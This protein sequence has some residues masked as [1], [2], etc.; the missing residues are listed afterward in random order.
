[1]KAEAQPLSA[2]LFANV[3]FLVPF[4]QRSYSWDRTNWERLVDDIQGLLDE[5]LEK[6]HF[7]GPLVCSLQSATPGSV[8]QFQLIDGQQ[9]I[10]T[11]SVL[12]IAIRDEAKRSDQ[13]E[14][15]EEIDENYLINKRRKALERYK[16]VPRTGDRE[17]FTALVDSKSV[18]DP[19]SRLAS[20]HEFFTKFIRTH[21]H[22][23][24]EYL[25]K[26]FITVVNRLFLVSIT[27]DK[28]DPYEIFESL[29]STGLPLQESDLIRNFL[30][31]QIPLEDQEDFQNEHWAPFEAQFDPAAGESTLSA[32]G[33][34]RDFLMRGGK[35]SKSKETFND[36]KRHYEEQ[37]LSPTEM[38]ALLQRFVGH[39]KSIVN[40]DSVASPKVAKVLRQFVWMEAST[41][42]PV[43]LNL[44]ER[45]HQKT[46][47]DD[48]FVACVSDLNSFILRRSI[49]GESTRGY[50]KLFCTLAGQLDGD[51]QSQI[52]GYLLERGWPDD[53]A[54][55]RSLAEF[56]LYRREFKKCRIILE[57]LERSDGHKEVVDL[58][59]IQI[60]HV[61]PQKLPGGKAGQEWKGMLG[62][63]PKRAHERLVHTLGNLTL[64]GYNPTLSNRAFSEKRKELAQSKLTLNKIFEI[65]GEKEGKLDP[66][67]TWNVDQITSRGKSLAAEVSGLWVRPDSN[68]E[69]VPPAKS[70]SAGNKG[71]QRRKEYWAA[72][73]DM[74][75]SSGVSVRPVR[76]IEGR[77]CDF[78]LPM[79]DV[80]LSA[81]LVT[82]KNQLTVAFQFARA[83]GKQIYDG[84]VADRE[85]IDAG[86]ETPPTWDD[87]KKPTITFVRHNVSIRDRYDWLDQHNWIIAT[88][89]Q[90]EN[91]L[92]GRLRSL[93]GAVKDRIEAELPRLLDRI[94]SIGVRS[95]ERAARNDSLATALEQLRHRPFWHLD[96]S[97]YPSQ[98]V[99][100]D[101]DAVDGHQDVTR[102]LP[103]THRRQASNR[104]R[105]RIATRLERFIRTEA[106]ADRIQ[107]IRRRVR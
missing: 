104:I 30:F 57:Q 67:L 47:S 22:R 49:C 14:L 42:F 33:F 23:D 21:A 55:E 4:F 83:R 48:D 91:E 73:A 95:K 84:L 88:L 86:F 38:V 76:T 63:R 7:L 8:S 5:D 100:H 93:H 17:L 20:A 78:Y 89:A 11:L 90:I 74:L 107:R 65:T 96:G 56:P 1:M 98:Q 101:G 97:N 60:E 41:A 13:E 9:R 99:H 10:T 12:L 58:E 53:E 87:G 45:R 103:A 68:V 39:A 32:T 18:S 44:L 75:S 102:L 69:Y 51:T 61:M 77:I 24:N 52:R 31:M 34:Y 3:Q 59:K 25:Q 40:H 105:L 94:P 106:M 72:L 64:T 71:K 28:E 15:A 43:V 29:N 19:N 85:S 62:D 46:M 81:R 6:K 92:L 37:N 36:F 54:F 26:L 16:L 82:N 2:L 35:Y 70:S 27:L 50:G 66:K 80:N 79:A